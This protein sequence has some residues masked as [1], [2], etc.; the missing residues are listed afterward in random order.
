MPDG[1]EIHLPFTQV[2]NWR[3]QGNDEFMLIKVKMLKLN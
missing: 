1:G 2:W 3:D